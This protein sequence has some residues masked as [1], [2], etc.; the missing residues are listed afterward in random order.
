MNYTFW[1]RNVYVHG[2]K[3][4]LSQSF[5]YFLKLSSLTEILPCGIL[6]RPFDAH[7]HQ[8]IQRKSSDHSHGLLLSTAVPEAQALCHNICSRCMFRQKL[9]GR[10][11][12][13]HVICTRDGGYLCPLPWLLMVLC[14]QLLHPL[15]EEIV[16]SWFSIDPMGH[17]LFQRL[18]NTLK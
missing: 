6:I 12:A 14:L 1:T 13:H 11:R 4:L 7:E 8:W 18:K 10:D 16:A 9:T 5:F 15:E 17:F 2:N 3:S